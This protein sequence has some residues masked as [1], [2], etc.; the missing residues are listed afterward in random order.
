[1]DSPRA[2]IVV[3]AVGWALAIFA[4]GILVGTQLDSD[5]PATSRQSAGQGS[6]A[7]VAVQRDTA[8]EPDPAHG[9]PL[10]V[11]LRDVRGELAIGPTGSGGEK[12]RRAGPGGGVSG[13]RLVSGRSQGGGGG[14]RASSPAVSPAPSPPPRAQRRAQRRRGHRGGQQRR[15]HRRSRP[16]APPAAPLAPFVAPP[17]Q[18]DRHRG[19]GRGHDDDGHRG[20]GHD[21]D[22]DGDD[23]HEDDD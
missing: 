8:R 18:P 21:R 9:A 3:A 14:A 23:D 2:W 12:P 4:G 10:R 11:A 16:P 5:D 17:P 15:T 7:V 6:G 19:H 22:G 20:H 1:V 13:A